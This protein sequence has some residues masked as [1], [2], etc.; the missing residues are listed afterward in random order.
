MCA[1]SRNSLLTSRRPDSLKL[2]DFYSYWRE[3]A[4]NYTTLPQHFRENGYLTQSIG[5]VFHPGISSNFTDDAEYSWSFPPFHPPTEI[6]KNA[7]VCPTAKWGLQNNLNCPIIVEE[8]PEE[9]LPDLQSLNE[10]IEFLKKW[11]NK[12]EKSP[13]FLAVGFHKPHIPFKFPINYLG[14]LHFAKIPETLFY[15]EKKFSN[16]T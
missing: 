7:K 15:L 5:K 6:F 13:Y 4:G 2:Y 9:S 16:L 1:P 12:K 10:A 8:Q 3:T 14:E 11:R